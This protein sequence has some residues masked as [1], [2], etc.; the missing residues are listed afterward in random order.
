MY[1]RQ[2]LQGRLALVLLPLED[3]DGTFTAALEETE[4]GLVQVDP[5]WCDPCWQMSNRAVPP[6]PC[7]ASLKE[8]AGEGRFGFHFSLLSVHGSRFGSHFGPIFGSH[9]GPI[10]GSHFGPIFGS[11]FGPHTDSL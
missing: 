7:G 8:Q 2:L 4:Q 11:H 9:F 6:L 1:K 3:A 10:F 5:Y